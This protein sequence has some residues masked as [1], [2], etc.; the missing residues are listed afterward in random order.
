MGFGGFKDG[1]VFATFL[2]KVKLSSDQP[3]AT[4]FISSFQV[5]IEENNYTYSTVTK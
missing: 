2:F 4:G 1:R 5:Y 3:S